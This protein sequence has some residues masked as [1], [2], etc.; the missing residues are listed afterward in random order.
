MI[1]PE[2]YAKLEEKYTYERDKRLQHQPEGAKQFVKLNEESFKD[3]NEDRFINYD[4]VDANQPLRDGSKTKVLITGGGHGGLLMA[5]R[6]IQA[7]LDPNDIVIVDKAGGFGGTWY[8]NRY[9]GLMCDIEGYCYMPLLEETGYVPQHRYSYG[10][11]I[12]EHTER[13]ARQWKIRGQFATETTYQKW[14]EEKRRWIVSLVQTTRPGETKPLQVE[15]QFV[16]LATGVFPIPYLPRLNGFDEMRKNVTVLH[17]SRWDYELTGGT[18]K[19]P[20]MT[21]LKGKV[22]GIVGTGATSLQLVPQLAKWAKHVYVFQRTPSF[23]S[24]RGQKETTP[25]DWAKVANKPGWQYDRM[26]NFNA[27][28]S[29]EEVDVDL[30]ND[31]WTHSSTVSGLLGSSRTLVTPDKVGEHLKY[32]KTMDFEVG[33]RVRQNMERQIDDPETAEKLK[34]WYYGWCKRPAFHDDYLPSFNMDHV[35]L[36]DLD[37]KGL[38]KC[39]SKGVVA[40]GTDYEVDFMV[41]ATGFLHSATSSPAL[42][43]GGPIPVLGRG[44]RT[45]EENFSAKD[46]NTFHGIATN[47]FPNLFFFGPRGTGVSGN[48]TSSFDIVGRQI[49]YVIDEGTKKSVDPDQTVLEVTEEA[50]QAW[51][52]EIVKRA[53]WWATMK[54]CTP[55]YFT[56]HGEGLKDLPPDEALLGARKAGFGGGA[57]AYSLILE[58][59]RKNGGLP[60][61]LVQG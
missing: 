47:G 34:P 5:V 19:Q 16:L 28:V 35:T 32:M 37:G 1:S 50:E 41:F 31:G 17:T 13:I 11:E 53:A 48:L 43:S 54:A 21:K 26:A 29:K 44:D 52:D 4:A 55:G 6:L 59:Y 58:G 39:H 8:W 20:D 60:G 2:L 57:N 25:E 18:Q 23:V 56:S 33:E 46:F 38:D 24:Y 42:G 12:R 30:V 10:Y 61:I 40:N 14:D 49:A 15:A 7:G 45:L 36:V 9:P 3:L 22:V 51:G 27:N